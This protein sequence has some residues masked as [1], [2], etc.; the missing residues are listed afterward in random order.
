MLRFHSE[1]TQLCLVLLRPSARHESLTVLTALIGWET[2]SIGLDV[3]ARTF[4]VVR[5]AQ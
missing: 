4:Q 1:T 2:G 5:K 3:V